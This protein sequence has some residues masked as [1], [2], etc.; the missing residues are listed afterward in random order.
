MG[1]PAF[2]N[3][4]RTYTAMVAIAEKLAAGEAAAAAASVLLPAILV[5]ACKHLHAKQSSCPSCNMHPLLGFRD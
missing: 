3:Y 1:S 5:L 2:Q 4:H